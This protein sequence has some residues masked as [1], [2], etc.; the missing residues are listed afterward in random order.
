MSTLCPFRLL[1]S[2][3]LPKVEYRL[4]KICLNTLPIAD[5]LASFGLEN[6]T[7]NAYTNIALAYMAVRLKN[8]QRHIATQLRFQLTNNAEL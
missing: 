7:E 1:V 8:N 5:K 6:L 3:F 4:T 2:F